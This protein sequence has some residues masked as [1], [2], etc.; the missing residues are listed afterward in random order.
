MTPK[1]H[2]AAIVAHGVRPRL[3][4]VSILDH[5]D[6][7]VRVQ[8]GHSTL[9]LANPVGFWRCTRRSRAA[10]IERSHGHALAIS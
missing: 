8:V 10:A 7:V 1:M 6:R 9:K 2:S 3:D 5:G 4:K